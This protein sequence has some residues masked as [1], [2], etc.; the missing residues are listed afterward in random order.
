MARVTMELPDEAFA[1]LRLD[2]DGMAREMR[3]AVA[4]YH[5]HRAAVSQEVA[6]QIA[7]MTRLEFLDTLARARLDTLVVDLA[8]LRRE[9]DDD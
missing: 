8:D 7:G 4:V 3:W 1:A 9:L 2:P 5:Y 6:A